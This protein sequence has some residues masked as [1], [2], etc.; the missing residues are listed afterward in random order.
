[1]TWKHIYEVQS[2]EEFFASYDQ[3]GSLCMMLQSA[4]KFDECF[5]CYV[6][7]QERVRVMKYDPRQPHHMRYSNDDLKIP[8][9]LYVRMKNDALALCRALG[10]EMN[11]VE[12]AVENGVP[13]AIDFLNPAPEA[14]VHLVGDA[15]FEWIVE[16]VAELAISKAIAPAEQP[17]S[18]RW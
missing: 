1:G 16:N 18:Y 17:A 9:E 8:L 10:Y 11:M 15:N 12:F 14:D 13:Y 4:V 3:T 7:G 2:R 6:M 5:R